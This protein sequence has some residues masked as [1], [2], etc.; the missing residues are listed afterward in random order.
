MHCLWTLPEGHTDFSGRWQAI[1]AEFSKRMPKAEPSSASRIA[2]G[3]R[4]IWQRHFWEHMIC[5]ERDYRVHMDY[6]HF[7]PVKL[8][9]VADVAD[10]PF[11]SYHRCDQRP[12]SI[13]PGRR[14]DRLH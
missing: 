8:G 4:S 6:I 1:K 12:V 7:N 14:N 3:E 10:W 5:D 11:S 13:G 9:L 2:K